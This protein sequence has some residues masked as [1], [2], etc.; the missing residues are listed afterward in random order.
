MTNVRVGKRRYWSRFHIIIV[1]TIHTYVVRNSKVDTNSCNNGLAPLRLPLVRAAG[2]FLRSVPICDRGR[3]SSQ[4]ERAGSAMWDFRE[5]AG[6]RV[7]RPGG[8][9]LT[10]TRPFALFAFLSYPARNGILQIGRH[11]ALVS[12]YLMRTHLLSVTFH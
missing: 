2:G 8:S 1:H 3:S 11:S 9:R 10:S 6:V 5:A 12:D 7:R 4:E